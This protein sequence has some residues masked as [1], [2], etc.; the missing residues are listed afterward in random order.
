MY[1]I[2]HKIYSIIVIA[3]GAFN[4][5]LDRRYMKN[6]RK[7]KKENKTHTQCSNT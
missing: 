2:F 5:G 1:A 6:R 3:Q 7:K 4:S